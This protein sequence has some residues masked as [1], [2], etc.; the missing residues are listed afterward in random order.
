MLL[1]NTNTGLMSAS[2]TTNGGAANGAGESKKKK[3]AE[4]EELVV[5]NFLMYLE[6]LELTAASLRTTQQL[7]AA[8]AHWREFQSRL[9]HW[10]VYS[11]PLKAVST[12]ASDYASVAAI[13]QRRLK[14]HQVCVGCHAVLCCVVL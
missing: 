12:F 11:L 3:S 5:P 9:R 14:Q 10:T 6:Q 4:E 2:K 13:A 7:W 1:T 8:L